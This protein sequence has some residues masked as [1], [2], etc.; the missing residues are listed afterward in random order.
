MKRF[1]KNIFLK[2]HILTS[3]EFIWF[4]YVQYKRKKINTDFKKRNPKIKL[5]SDFYL[6]ETF[7]LDYEKYYSGGKT[8]AKW[9]VNYIKRYIDV[10]NKKIL[11]W[12]CGPGRIIRHL[13]EISDASN[14]FFGSDYNI[15]YVDWCNENLHCIHVKKNLIAPPLDFESNFFDIIYSISIFTHLSE[16]MHHQWIKELNRVSKKEAILFITT[17]GNNFKKKLTKKEQL[18]FSS[19]KLIEHQYKIEGNRLFAAYQPPSF[20]KILCEEN[21]FTVLLHD[22][23][24]SEVSKP[25]QDVWILKKS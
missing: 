12:G 24:K 6:Y 9:V 22:E 11:D 2:L 7:D 14:F 23:R 20:F 25:N 13:P 5:P 15:E 3:I 17:H 10:N 19:G 4:K 1:L 8:T 21:G 16:K 18:N